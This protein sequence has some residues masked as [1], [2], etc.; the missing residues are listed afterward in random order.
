[1]KLPICPPH[2]DHLILIF[3]VVSSIAGAYWAHRLSVKSLFLLEKKNTVK[4]EKTIEKTIQKAKK[5]E[6]ANK[7]VDQ[8]GD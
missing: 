5:Q 3:F 2:L 1:M 8:M 7:H 4:T 6:Q